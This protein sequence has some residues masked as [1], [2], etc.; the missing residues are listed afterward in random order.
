V[1]VFF[2]PYSL[3][4]PVNELP[5]YSQATGILNT[6]TNWLDG[7][8]LFAAAGLPYQLAQ[9]NSNYT[10]AVHQTGKLSMAS[11]TPH[12]WGCVQYSLGRRYYESDGGEGIALQWQSI[13]TNQPDWV[14]ITTWNDFNES[15][16]LSPV[17]NPGQ[18][19][20]QLENPMRNCHAA[21]SELSR[22]YIAWFKTGRQ[23]DIDADALYYFYRVHPKNAVALNT[24]DS[25][26]VAFGGN[27]QDT[28]YATVL[29]AGPA[30]LEVH[31]GGF[32]TTNSLPA[33]Q[34]MLRTP[35]APGPQKLV[36]TRNGSQV[37]AI[38]GPDI[39]TNIQ[40]YNFFPAT[41]FAYGRP[42]APKNLR[43][44]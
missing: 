28:L 9:C 33:G 30:Q 32:S 37:L 39:Q 40:L 23:P 24:N 12:Y 29:L 4:N 35:F 11:V 5:G 20:S 2:V 42:L 27:V 14:E 31:S 34:S 38:Q 3:S 10:L 44:Y 17:V 7:L 41:G 1:P 19:F 16:Y 8:F 25:P 18:Y 43:A 26:V 13:L 15:T 36:L 22:R 6:Y 21:Y